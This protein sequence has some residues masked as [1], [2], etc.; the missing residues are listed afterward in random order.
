MKLV[1]WKHLCHVWSLNWDKS[2]FLYH[3]QCIYLYISS[4]LH[5]GRTHRHP[6]I[7]PLCP[8]LS[9]TGMPTEEQTHT[10]SLLSRS[11]SFSSI[12]LTDRHTHSLS[13][14]FIA[15]LLSFFLFILSSSLHFSLSHSFYLLLS[16]ARTLCLSLLFIS[17]SHS[18]FSLITLANCL[19]LS[20]F[21]FALPQSPSPPL[22]GYL[23]SSLHFALPD[24]LSLFSFIALADSHTLPPRQPSSFFSDSH[25]FPI[26]FSLHFLIS[27]SF[28]LLLS[29]PH[30]ISLSL[31]PFLSLT[32]SIS[33]YFDPLSIHHSQ[34]LS[35]HFS[36]SVSIS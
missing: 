28:H 12:A 11:L 32:L 20:L 15:L 5:H 30:T 8:P 17:P 25:F 22:S 26:S 7:L 3:S 31:H 10:P 34:I 13:L 9:L 19:P 2:Y 23:P 24:T 29:Q 36:L 6:Y 27:L 35:L 16:Q 33:L 14:L 1:D 21:I 4:S 18:L